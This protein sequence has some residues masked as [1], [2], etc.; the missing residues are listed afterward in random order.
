MGMGMGFPIIDI[1]WHRHMLILEAKLECLPIPNS[2]WAYQTT[3]IEHILI[4]FSYSTPIPATKRA[5][6]V[7]DFHIGKG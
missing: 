4:F 6:S 2:D 3:N 1:F 5:Q 7:V